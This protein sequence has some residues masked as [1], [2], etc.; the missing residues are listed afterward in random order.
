MNEFTGFTYGQI[1]YAIAKRIGA[2]AMNSEQIKEW[3]EREKKYGE[4]HAAQ[5]ALDYIGALERERD[6]LRKAV[7]RLLTAC[8]KVDRVQGWGAILRRA[9]D[10]AENALTPP[11]S[12]EK[13]GEHGEAK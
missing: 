1:H 5:A 4:F 11:A 3:L 13:G 7:K 9:M 6:S 12:G 2:P 10:F 8:R